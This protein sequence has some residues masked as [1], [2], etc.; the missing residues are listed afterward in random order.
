LAVQLNIRSR[1]TQAYH[2]L[3]HAYV[4]I[5]I[6]EQA[7]GVVS[8]MLEVAQ[9]RYSLGKLPQQEIF[10][11]QTQLSILEARIIEMQRDQKMAEAEINNLLNR[12]PGS[13]VGEPVMSGDEPVLPSLESLLERAGDSAPE[14]KRNQKMIERGELQVNLARKD[15]HPDYTVAAGYYYMGTMSPMYQVRVDIP[16]RIFGEKRQRPA[17]AEQVDR[18]AEARR[19][20]EVADQSLQFRIREAYISAESALRLAKLYKSTILPQSSLTI[21]SALTAYANGTGDQTSVLTNVIAKTDSEERLHEAELSCLLALARLEELT[22]AS[23]LS[24]GERQ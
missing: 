9:L 3:H 22:G 10:R 21:E 1:V 20:Y 16:I 6:L 7:R 4:A 24:E 11:T 15:F 14:L 19:N 8:Q 18:L 23:I 17:L 2:R 5:G 13:A 12:K